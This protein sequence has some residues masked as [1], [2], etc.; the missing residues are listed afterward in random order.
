MHLFSPRFFCA[1][2]ACLALLWYAPLS[3]AAE[4]S[5]QEYKLKAGFLFNLA[6]LTEWPDSVFSDPDVPF[7]ICFV[8]EDVFGKAALNTIA[9]KKVR[10][11][12]VQL[13]QEISLEQ[14]ETCQILFIPAA[15]EKDLPKILERL[16]ELPILTVADMEEFAQRGGMVNLLKQKGRIALEINLQASKKAGLKIS[17]RVLKLATIIE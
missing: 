15:E 17:A 9:N 2:G 7:N 4:D 16:V 13:Q 11:H 1:V 3:I 8:G 6:R 14:A 10:T 5:S 12:P